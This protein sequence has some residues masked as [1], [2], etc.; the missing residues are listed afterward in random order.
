MATLF[1]WKSPKS[2]QNKKVGFRSPTLD[3]LTLARA[4]S[5]VDE[6][7]REEIAPLLKL[8][9]QGDERTFVFTPLRGGSDLTPSFRK[10]NTEHFTVSQ[11]LLGGPDEDFVFEETKRIAEESWMTEVGDERGLQNPDPVSASKKYLIHL[12][13]LPGYYGVTYPQKCKGPVCDSFLEVDQDFD[14]VMTGAETQEERRA[15]L[16]ANLEVTIAHE[17][18]HAIQF[19]HYALL[20]VDDESRVRLDGWAV[21]GGAVWMED[22]VYPANND[23]IQTYLNSFLAFPELSWTGVNFQNPTHVYGTTM[24]FKSLSDLLPGGPDT[25][26]KFYQTWSTGDYPNAISALE[27][28]LRPMNEN[29]TQVA[30]DLWVGVTADW[31]LDSPAFPGVSPYTIFSQLPR[32]DRISICELCTYIISLNAEQ[33]GGVQD[34]NFLVSGGGGER[35][36]SVVVNYKDGRPN[37]VIPLKVDPEEALTVLRGGLDQVDMNKVAFI[38]LVIT[39]GPKSSGVLD[40]IISST[41]QPPERK[42]FSLKL[43]NGW[44][45]IALPLLA[46]T[47]VRFWLNKGENILVPG[48]SNDRFTYQTPEEAGWPPGGVPGM[49]LAVFESDAK[50]RVIQM[51]GVHYVGAPF[52]QRLYVGYN[53]VGNPLYE[54]VNLSARAVFKTTS[55][56]SLTLA[57]AREGGWI[58]QGLWTLKNGAYVQLTTDTLEPGQ[59]GWLLMRRG[60][61]TMVIQ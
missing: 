33:Q 59:A 3:V 9:T 18:F 26:R 5:F 15:K 27:A 7:T 10:E 46:D 31:F 55:G 36:A 23:Y 43:Q 29:V 54:T 45:F 32:Q 30:H 52:T 16:T 40:Y 42:P 8:E 13:A 48:F 47:S 28:T 57:Q 17:F 37:A 53:L 14:F 61:L 11:D 44:N 2:L 24:Y 19:A 51:T 34:L 49:P 21:E 50:G 60:A 20:R 58:G 56:V 1:A 6:A 22:Q 4:M 35:M 12:T 39:T 25:V 41:P 38:S